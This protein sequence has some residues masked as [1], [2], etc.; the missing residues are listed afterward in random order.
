MVE[1]KILDFDDDITKRCSNGINYFA[2]QEECAKYHQ[3]LNI[4]LNLIDVLPTI[5][6]SVAIN[7]R[8]NR[9]PRNNNHELEIDLI[10]LNLNDF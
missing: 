4:P 2:T 10:E 5:V 6:E 1:I 7:S 9:S 8:K 3:H